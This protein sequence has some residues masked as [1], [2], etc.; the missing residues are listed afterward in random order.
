[1]VGF[2]CDKKKALIVARINLPTRLVFSGVAAKWRI[3]T[4]NCVAFVVATV[5]TESPTPGEHDVWKLRAKFFALSETNDALLAFL[6]ETGAWSNG[7]QV[8]WPQSIRHIHEFPFRVK[9]VS[10]IWEYRNRLRRALLN[11]AAFRESF[12]AKNSE[13]PVKFKLTATTVEG[14]IEAFDTAQ[15]LLASVLIDAARGIRFKM[16]ARKDCDELFPIES[17]HKR[18]FCSQYCGHLVS[19]RRERE[20]EQRAK[21]TEAKRKA[22]R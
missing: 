18:K 5:D 11:K 10:A 14:I 16:C 21:R 6:N 12:E 22:L 13:F 4:H 9:Q 19:M 2:L 1:M 17:R 20:R 8:S 3:E 7:E 15:A